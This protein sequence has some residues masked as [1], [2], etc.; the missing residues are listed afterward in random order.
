MAAS[1]EGVGQAGGH[2]TAVDE[3]WE[4][5]NNLGAAIVVVYYLAHRQAGAKPGHGGRIGSGGSRRV[6]G[7]IVRENDFRMGADGSRHYRARVDRYGAG[8]V[9]RSDQITVIGLDYQRW[10]RQSNGR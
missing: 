10:V 8:E 4:V 5:G 9:C 2:R 3:Q 1:A 6:N 7:V